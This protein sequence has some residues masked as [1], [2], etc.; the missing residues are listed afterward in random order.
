MLF[1]VQYFWAKGKHYVYIIFVQENYAFYKIMH[2][3]FSLVT[4]KY[5]LTCWGWGRSKINNLIEN[6]VLSGKGKSR[7]DIDLFHNLEIYKHRQS[8]VLYCESDEAAQDKAWYIL[9]VKSICF[10]FLPPSPNILYQAAIFSWPS[11][12]SL[13]LP[14]SFQKCMLSLTVSVNNQQLP[15]LPL[16][17]LLCFALL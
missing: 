6:Q 9:K 11:I 16:G 17:E 8:S 2:V 1:L 3:I 14:F 7:S 13:D 12:L 5:S 15:S 10:D 4:K